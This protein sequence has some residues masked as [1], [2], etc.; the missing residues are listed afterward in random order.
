MFFL[1]L[2]KLYRAKGEVIPRFLVDV[3]KICRAFFTTWRR[4]AAPF[5]QHGEVLPRLFYNMARLYR[6]P[7]KDLPRPL[8]K[9][10]RAWRGF[11]APWRGYTALLARICRAF[12]ACEKCRTSNYRAVAPF[13]TQ[14]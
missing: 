3:A 4:F 6:A 9:L 5:L 11:A 10:Y 8:A 2:P 12:V 13:M 14:G 1:Q 7:G